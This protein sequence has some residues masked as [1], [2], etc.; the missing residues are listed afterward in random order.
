MELTNTDTEKMNTDSIPEKKDFSE[1]FED[2]F[3]GIYNFVYA[4]ILHRE[5]TEDLVSEIFMKAM[6]HYASFD[7]SIRSL[8]NSA[9]AVVPRSTLW[10]RIRSM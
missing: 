4:R 3:S 6:K 1:V 2:N 8:M 7:P 9:K 5:R 10:T